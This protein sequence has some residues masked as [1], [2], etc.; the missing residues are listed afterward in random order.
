MQ[1]KL[2]F[3]VHV[4]VEIKKSSQYSIHINISPFHLLVSQLPSADYKDCL[5]KDESNY[6]HRMI[7]TLIAALLN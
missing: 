3:C 1:N 5:N 6:K 4:Q 7:K 2:I